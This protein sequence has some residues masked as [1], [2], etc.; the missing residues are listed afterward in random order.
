MVSPCELA[1]PQAGDGFD[2]DGSAEGVCLAY[3]EC[4][5]VDLER[6][7]VQLVRDVSG[8]ARPTVPSPHLPGVLG[9]GVADGFV[10]AF[11]RKQKIEG[12]G[13]G[14]IHTHWP[15]VITCFRRFRLL[16]VGSKTSGQ[17]QKKQ[18]QGH[19]GT[20]THED[21]QHTQQLICE[22]VSALCGR[23]GLAGG[24]ATPVE[25]GTA[26]VSRPGEPL[27]DLHLDVLALMD[28][29]GGRGGTSRWRTTTPRTGTGYR[30]RT[31]GCAS[32]WTSAK[33]GDA[34]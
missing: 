10:G 2:D 31:W 21:L 34:S 27:M 8:S 18:H 5:V 32:T 17:R 6:R 9:R 13:F 3:L 28:D 12:K 15:R 30:T 22:S 33:R 19:E 11:L 7:A 20:S 26:R 25:P 4:W 29:G 1:S 16:D 24:P 14:L 23:P